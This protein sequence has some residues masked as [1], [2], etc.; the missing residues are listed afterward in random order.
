MCYSNPVG[1]RFSQ[2]GNIGEGIVVTV[3]YNGTPHKFKVEGE[4]HSKTKVRTL[5]AVDEAKE[6]AKHEF[7]NYACAGWRLEQMFN[8]NFNE[9][10]GLEAD[11]KHTG[12][13]L[14]AVIRDVM[15]EESDVMEEKGLEPKEVNSLISR[16]AR[17]WF[18][19]QI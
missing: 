17:Q 14:W 2:E 3:K 4:K 19:Q 1:Q 11:V 13:F 18:M 5:K 6:N 10:T 15:K 8:E 16:V 9:E 12:D 7:A